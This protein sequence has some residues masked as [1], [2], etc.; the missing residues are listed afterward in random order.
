MKLF[1]VKFKNCKCLEEKI[2]TMHADIETAMVASR[3]QLQGEIQ[4]KQKLFEISNA[5]W[6]HTVSE[7]KAELES[8]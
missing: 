1:E 2:Y 8:Y 6:K 5:D 4:E 3:N 7:L